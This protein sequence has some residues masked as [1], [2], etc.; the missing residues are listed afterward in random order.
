MM[1][2]YRQVELEQ[3]QRAFVAEPEKALLDL[4]HLQ[5]RGDESA[6]L[7]ALRLDFAELELDRLDSLATGCAMPKLTRAAGRIR[8]LA[9]EAPDY[10]A[11]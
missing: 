7:R 1:F 10:E 6:Y 2:G 5:P 8:D 3:G 9:A 4:V 11:L